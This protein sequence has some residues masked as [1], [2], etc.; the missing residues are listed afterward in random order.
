MGAALILFLLGFGALAAGI[1]IGRYYVPDDRM[2]KRTAKHS[3][4]YMRAINH[5]LARDKDA[6]IDELKR[7]VSEN[8]DEIEPYFAL[9]ALFRSR[10]E[11]ER[12]IRVHQAI[13]LRE[14]ASKKIRLRARY[15]LGLDFRVAGMPRRATRAMEDCLEQDSKHMGALRALCGLYEEQGRFAEA[16]DAWRRLHKLQG[17]TRVA[18]EHHLLVAAAQKSIEVGQLDSAKRLLKD[19]ERIIDDTPH[20]LAAGA[21]LA[22]AKDDPKT[23]RTKLRH[24]LTVAPDLAA[25]LVPGLIEAER[26][27]VK[28]ILAKERKKSG[29]VED[30]D[31]EAASEREDN[32]VAERTVGTLEEVLDITGPNPHIELAAAEMRAHFDAT[33]ALAGYRSV[34]HAFPDVL[35][36][37]V[38]S[39][40]LALAAEKDDDITTELNALAGEGGA[41]DWASDGVWRCGHCVHPSETFFWRCTECRRWGTAR[42]DV[43][44]SAQLPPPPP[45]RERRELPR[46]GPEAA[47]LAASHEALPEAA[48]E[49]GMSDVELAEAGRRQSVLGRVGGWFSSKLG[50]NKKKDEDEDDDYD[51][52]RQLTE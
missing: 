6:A 43:G 23:A 39:A 19:A 8:I 45:P 1:L 2:I 26:Q 33:S 48:L 51:G 28:A 44:R 31:E 30:L 13:D 41:L 34:S 10:G 7:V 9:G 3:R 36:A 47:L 35:S 21:E 14:G 12:A 29:E 49:S 20:L 50:R 37:R 18:R 15:E 22:A 40:R 5:L 4:A 16:A 38:A 11:W 46:R 42:L 24:A 25:F 17:S 27:Q 52:P 32:M